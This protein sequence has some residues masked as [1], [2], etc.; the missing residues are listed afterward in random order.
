[1]VQASARLTD[2]HMIL[3]SGNMYGRPIGLP[4][5]HPHET[6]FHFFPFSSAVAATAIDLG[7]HGPSSDTLITSISLSSAVTSITFDCSRLFLDALQSAGAPANR[8]GIIHRALSITGAAESN[9]AGAH[10]HE[11]LYDLARGIAFIALDL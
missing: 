1:M 4:S 11:F 7:F 9:I 8:A 2:V 5:H 6:S 3:S 10:R